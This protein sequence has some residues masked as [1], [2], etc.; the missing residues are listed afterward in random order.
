MDLTLESAFST[1]GLVGHASYLLLVLSMMMRG[2]TLL[3]IFVILSAF[4][5][6]L[7]DMV[8]LKDPVGVFWESM[9]VLVN[10]VQ[11]VDHLAPE[12]LGA[13]QRRGKD[14]HGRALA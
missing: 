13:V 8:W 14:L 1:G 10:I 6:I 11:F 2:M 4:V 9:L 5:S 12:P 7:Y 3:R